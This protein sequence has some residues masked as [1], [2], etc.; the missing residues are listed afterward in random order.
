M[1]FRSG[2]LSC[3]AYV[4]LST[5]DLYAHFIVFMNICRLTGVL[6]LSYSSSATKLPASQAYPAW[7]LQLQGSIRSYG[8]STVYL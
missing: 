6:F 1:V 2:R 5:S 3:L 7:I 8:K 4:L